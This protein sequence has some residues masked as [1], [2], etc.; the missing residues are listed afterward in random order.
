MAPKS[1]VD[2]LTR[3][4]RKDPMEPRRSPRWEETRREFVRQHPQCEVCARAALG[5]LNVHHII[6]FDMAASCGR[7]DLELD[8]RNMITLC[9]GIQDHHLILGHLGD[10]QS[11]NQHVRNDAKRFDCIGQPSEKIRRAAW[12]IEAH[13]DRPTHLR[14][15][16]AADKAATKALLDRIFPR[17]ACG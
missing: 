10:R 16:S 6:P 14:G 11:Y 3:S 12:W 4:I 15:G 5:E 9:E 8:P 1:P 17:T 13:E 7:P 2:L